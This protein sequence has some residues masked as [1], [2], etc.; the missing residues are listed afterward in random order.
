[1]L[2]QRSFC[3]RSIRKYLK[4][5]RVKDDDSQLSCR[6]RSGQADRQ[7]LWSYA[8]LIEKSPFTAD[9]T[10]RIGFELITSGLP[11]LSLAWIR[12]ARATEVVDQLVMPL[13]DHKGPYSQCH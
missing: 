10:L 5:T 4:H 13:D 7:G 8:W 11:Q 12:S 6:H 9:M 3:L 2:P 1:M